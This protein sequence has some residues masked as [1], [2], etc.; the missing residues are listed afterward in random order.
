MRKSLSP[1][2]NAT[3]DIFYWIKEYIGS[4]VMELKIDDD[5]VESFDRNKEYQKVIGSSNIQT[6]QE[7]ALNIRKNG[8]YN[9]GSYMFPITKLYGYIE[10]KKDL[11]S[12]KDFNIS[13]RDKIITEN[14]YDS[15]AKTLQGIL[16]QIHSL[17]M[18]IEK[19]A[20]DKNGEP[21]YF[22][23]QKLDKDNPPLIEEEDLPYLKS[24]ELFHFIAMM[25]T[26]SFR[27]QSNP[28]KT[29]LMMKM[30]IFGGLRSEELGRLKNKDIKFIENPHPF[31]DGFYM[32][33]T[34]RDSAGKNKTA[35]IK[36][37]LI[38][39][40]GDYIQ[41]IE[42]C[43][44]DLFFCTNELKKYSVNS[45]FQ[46]ILRFFEHAELEVSSQSLKYSYAAYMLMN[47]VDISI[48]QILVALRHTE[49]E[50]LYN[51]IV[52]K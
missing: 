27:K 7:V 26:F 8:L 39:E 23:L 38:K 16:V 31:L 48:V 1:F 44:D 43:K 45:I 40:Y 17:F 32:K 9:L 19:Y 47:D 15:S 29:K 12:I 41:K 52:K 28:E 6:L 25:D 49:V 4:K 42:T 30:I 46:F 34:V 10:T 2:G 18:Y 50:K 13:Y 20:V 24:Y 22:N 37:T 5:Y 21:F 36:D 51:Q 35:Y 11:A 14:I 3:D 33:I